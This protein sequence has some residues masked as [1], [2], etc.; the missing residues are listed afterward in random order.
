MHLVRDLPWVDLLVN[1]RW[2]GLLVHARGMN[3]CSSPETTGPWPRRG[4]SRKVLRRQA[5][6]CR[7]PGCCTDGETRIRGSLRTETRKAR[8][9]HAIAFDEPHCGTVAT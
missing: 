8:L 7:Q 3:G 2:V 6:H 1:M 9:R 5:S 4:A